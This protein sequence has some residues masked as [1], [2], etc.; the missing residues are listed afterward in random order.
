MNSEKLDDMIGQMIMVGFRGLEAGQSSEIISDIHALNIGGVILFD[1]DVETKSKKRNIADKKQ[2]E[3]LTSGLQSI[4][5][6]PLFIAVDQEGG[7][8]A[9]LSPDCG[10][11]NSL[12]HEELG[13]IDNIETTGSEARLIANQVAGSG[14][15]VNLAPVVDLNTGVDNPIISGLG[16]SFSS[17]PL[18]VVKHAEVFMIEHAKQNVLT[19]IK[20]FI[21]HGSSK[22]DPHLG[23]VDVTDSYDEQEALPFRALIDK[24]IVDM[25]MTSHVFNRNFDELFPVTMSKKIIT[26]ILRNEMG[27]NGVVISDDTQMK[28]VADQYAA[29]EAVLNIVNAGVDILLISNNIS[30]NPAEHV[31]AIETISNAVKTGRISF[32]RIQS[33]F[34]RITKLKRKI[35]LID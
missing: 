5:K 2:V 9:R 22:N 24:G 30:Y 6:T 25:V 23:F 11:E 35:G 12:S 32:E 26:G 10:Y 14:L 1:Y 17:D 20:H 8:V 16:R 3:K 18:K 31:K 27:F 33:S 28:A 21:G 29:E 15:N 13:K 7:R 4:A 19:C 34:D